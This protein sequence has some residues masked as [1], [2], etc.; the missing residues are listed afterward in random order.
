MNNRMRVIKEKKRKRL[1]LSFVTF[2]L[3]NASKHQAGSPAVSRLATHLPIAYRINYIHP[4][5]ES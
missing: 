1:H 3:P 4:A 2:L 5:A